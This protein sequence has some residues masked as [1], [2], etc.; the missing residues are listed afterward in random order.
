MFPM[1]IKV[2]KISQEECNTCYDGNTCF[3][4]YATSNGVCIVFEKSHQIIIK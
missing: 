3:K 1:K 2:K 4:E